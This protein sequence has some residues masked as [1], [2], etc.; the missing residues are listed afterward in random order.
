VHFGSIIV[1]KGTRRRTRHREVLGL[2]FC[3]Q[4]PRLA[5]SVFLHTQIVQKEFVFL[6][7]RFL[8]LIL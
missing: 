4:E 7:Q 5:E 6:V 8:F 2:S 3:L 1:N